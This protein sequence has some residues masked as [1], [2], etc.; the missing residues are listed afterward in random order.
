[1]VKVLLLAGL[2][3][4]HRFVHHAR[5]TAAFLLQ[6]GVRLVVKVCGGGR[7]DVFLNRV[8][9]VEHF[10]VRALLYYARHLVRYFGLKQRKVRV[11]TVFVL[12]PADLGERLYILDA[13]AGV[14]LVV[15][16]YFLYLFGDYLFFFE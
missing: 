14:D 4:T 2:H 11:Q 6:V 10:A 13:G 8:V 3:G 1:L 5:H 16:G 12:D 9:R 15:Q 7:V